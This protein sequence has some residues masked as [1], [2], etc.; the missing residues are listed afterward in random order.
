MRHKSTLGYA[1]GVPLVFGVEQTIN[2]GEDVDVIL[3]NFGLMQNRKVERMVRYGHVCRREEY[4]CQ[5]RPLC[6]GDSTR[7]YCDEVSFP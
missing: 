1:H 5:R 3:F 4:D 2:R 6:K 7:L